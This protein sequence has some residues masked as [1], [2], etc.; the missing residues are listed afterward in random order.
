M[1]LY[2]LNSQSLTLNSLVTCHT[3][4]VTGPITSFPLR[5]QTRKI[6]RDRGQIAIDRSGPTTRCVNSRIF[7]RRSQF[8]LMRFQGR[9]LRFQFVDA[10]FAFAPRFGN[11]VASLSLGAFLAF[12]LS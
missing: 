8:L 2:A 11:C 3:S 5:C 10:L 9:D 12:L 4:L 7:Q 6:V 1:E